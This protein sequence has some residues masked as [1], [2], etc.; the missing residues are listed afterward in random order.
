MR[1]KWATGKRGDA[2]SLIEEKF[3]SGLRV[4]R[5]LVFEEGPQVKSR[6]Y[7][8]PLCKNATAKHGESSK[9]LQVLITLIAR[10]RWHLAAR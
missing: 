9:G 8:G 6:K 7:R 5:G 3:G 1:G 2:Q 10:G 4:T